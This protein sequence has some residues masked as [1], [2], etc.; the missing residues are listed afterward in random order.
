MNTEPET[1]K[2]TY[3]FY[4]GQIVY[5]L[6]KEPIIDNGE[7]TVTKATVFA[8]K[9]RTG[10]RLPN[11]YVRLWHYPTEEPGQGDPIVEKSYSELFTE[12]EILKMISEDT[13][14]LDADSM[15]IDSMIMDPVRQKELVVKLGTAT[16]LRFTH[17][18]NQS[19]QL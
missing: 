10:Q 11:P 17:D 13:E 8:T 9:D 1:P 16:M 6:G 4:N 14:S 5:L 2:Y 18:A 7:L 12:E 3:E 19:T 15:E